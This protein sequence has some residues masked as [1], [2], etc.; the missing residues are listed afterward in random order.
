MAIEKMTSM[1]RV[2][3][4]L[5]HNEPDRVPIFFLFTMHGANELGFSIFGGAPAAGMAQ[6]ET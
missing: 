5:S 1:Q 2:L 3:A 4:T 6:D